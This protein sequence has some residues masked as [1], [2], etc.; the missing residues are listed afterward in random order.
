[1][2]AAHILIVDDDTALLQALPEAL[3]LRMPDVTVD[4]TASAPAA[5]ER[6]VRTDYDAIVSDIK[7]PEMDGLT[8]LG[9]IRAIAP[10]TPTLL[11]TGHG[12]HDL[13]VQ[14]LRGGAYDFIQKPIDRDYFVASLSRAIHMRQLSRQVEQQ[15]LAIERHAATLEE[16]VRERTHELL[17]AN[18]AKDDLL[19]ARDRALAETTLARDRLSF[20]A[21]ASAILA[22]SL[23]YQT[24][25][26]NVAQ[27]AVPL[28]ADW[29]LVH[30]VADDGSA[31]LLA[32]AHVD[33][34]K[35]QLLRDRFPTLPDHDTST[36]QVLRTGQT[37][38]HTDIGDAQLRAYAGDDDD[39]LAMMRELGVHAYICVPMTARG[40]TIGTIACINGASRRRFGPDE[41]SLMEDLAC[42]A[43]L[44]ADNARLYHE[45][46]ASAEEEA[47]ARQRVETLAAL[48]GQ[49]AGELNTIIEAMPNGVYVCDRD[50]QMIRVNASGARL[51]GLTKEEVLKPN[52]E[53]RRTH[54]AYN[55]DGTLMPAQDYP[56]AQALRGV[57]RDDFRYVVHL[58]ASGQNIH[59]RAACAPMRDSAG[60]ITGAVSVASD[61]TELYR[62]ERHKEEFLSIASHELK[63]PLTSLKTLAQ[64][65][66]RRLEREDVA[67]PSHLIGME[68]AISR[69]ETLVDDILDVSRIESGKLALR[70]ERSDLVGICR[71][72][73]EEQAAASGRA[74]T[75]DVPDGSVPIEVDV[76]RI[77]QVLANLLSNALKYSPQA[78]PVTLTIARVG[79][80]AVIRVRDH[81]QGIPPEELP[82]IF[83]RF[84]RVPG[85]QVQVGSGVGLGLGLYISCEI[86]E[87]HGGRIWAESKQGE[88]S[89]FSVAL[90]LAV[91][92]RSRR[93]ARAAMAADSAHST[94]SQY[95]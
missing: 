35:A 43:A 1:M 67:V 93:R 95:S 64:L 51:L 19:R 2:T 72:A 69:M 82:R 80:E 83:D 27:L 45:A 76:D 29:C 10:A 36:A 56:L 66:H 94:G 7:M 54:T 74:I 16:T 87:R 55:L 11:I 77:S 81:G 92:A 89:T 24:T 40:R 91:P 21:E 38:L 42:R 79:E 48:L 22:S 17:E 32:A 37:L 4:T 25:L 12:E 26:T 28:L 65:T 41:Q 62:L 85:I 46:Q 14:A 75:L 88:G 73:A 20:L 53:F 9:H 50:G 47:A 33:P 44:A 30:I 39:Y 86:V 3:R 71:Q 63:T 70:P 84:Y 68:R 49:Q 34:D 5:L 6:I 61:V 15:R 52:V 60:V 58:H 18:Q 90:P 23:D 13:A 78:S 8:L 57:T 59:V 31:K